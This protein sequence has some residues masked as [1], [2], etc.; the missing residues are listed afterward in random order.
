MT[1][2]C[3]FAVSLL[4]N[5]PC[6]NNDATTTTTSTTTTTTTTPTATATVAT[7]VAGAGAAGV[8]RMRDLVAAGEVE[9]AKQRGQLGEISA[10]LFT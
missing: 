7:T 9:T 5:S 1:Y 10:R 4:G 8:V 6:S 2:I 3:L